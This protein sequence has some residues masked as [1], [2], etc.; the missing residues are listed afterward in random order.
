[1]N[2]VLDG[3]DIPC[4]VTFVH[5]STQPAEVDLAELS[6][7]FGNGRKSQTGAWQLP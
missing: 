6:C 3:S 5:S 2:V 7:D 4:K 1:M